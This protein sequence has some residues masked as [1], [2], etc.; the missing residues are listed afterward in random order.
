MIEKFEEKMMKV[1]LLPTQDCEA[2]YG[3]GVWF[4]NQIKNHH[5]VMMQSTDQ[6]PIRFSTLK[7][8]RYF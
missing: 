7:W 2:G 4:P 8:P 5:F 3:P 6:L 1:D